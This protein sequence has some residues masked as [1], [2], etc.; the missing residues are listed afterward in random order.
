[1]GNI[2]PV[3]KNRMMTQLMAP[4]NQDD[5]K[6]VVSALTDLEDGKLGHATITPFPSFEVKYA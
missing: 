4:P 3:T 6:K 2:D 5:L 1:M